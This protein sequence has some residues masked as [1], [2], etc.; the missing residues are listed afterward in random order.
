MDE[1]DSTT[2][3]L[4]HVE[5]LDKPEGDHVSSDTSL[6]ALVT[7]SGK[8]NVPP[9]LLANQWQKGRSGNPNGIQGQAPW[10]RAL[11]EGGT[12]AEAAAILWSIARGKAGL[13]RD[14]RP[15]AEYIFSQLAG[16]P[17]MTVDLGVS[18]DDPA[19]QAM[20]ALWSALR[21]EAEPPTDPPALPP[22][23]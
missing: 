2:T 3:E 6:S 15:A 21:G 7:D 9:Q 23:T 18:E 19:V 11:A 17:R 5:V 4:P 1:G 16:A 10:R 13:S 12:P 20:H 22:A 14:Q 8:R